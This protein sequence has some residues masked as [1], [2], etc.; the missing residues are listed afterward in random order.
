MENVQNDNTSRFNST[1]HCGCGVFDTKI[2]SKRKD[3]TCQTMSG[4]PL[5]SSSSL[6]DRQYQWGICSTY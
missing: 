4:N 2:N 1:F 3:F 6:H 5:T